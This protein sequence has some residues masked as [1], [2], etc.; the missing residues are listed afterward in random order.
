MPHLLDI[1]SLQASHFSQRR[2]GQ[3]RRRA[4]AQPARYQLQQRQPRRGIAGIQPSCDNG[5]QLR[6]GRDGQGVHN[7]RQAWGG[8]VCACLR[9]D[10]RHGF[11]EIAD[12]IIG[13][14]EQ[15]RIG[16]ALRQRP[17]QPGLGGGESQ[18]ARNGGQAPAAL[19]VRLGA[20]IPAQQRELGQAPRR[21]HQAFE[22]GGKGDHSASSSNPTS[23]SARPR[24]PRAAA[25]WINASS[26]PCVTQISGAPTS[27]M[28]RS[29]SSQSA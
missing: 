4:N 26:R 9:P 25:A 5:R 21:E 14:S 22:Q 27:S 19:R 15:H 3:T 1:I 10:Q 7:L 28:V 13:Q 17:D 16:P 8:C 24:M 23:R 20:E 29:S 11:R 12:V 18:R 6:L 2:L